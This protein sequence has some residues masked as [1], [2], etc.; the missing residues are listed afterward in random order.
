M[1]T[2]PR[3]RSAMEP[4]IALNEGPSKW[5]LTC[6]N[7]KCNTYYNT[8]APQPHQE[9]FHRDPHRFTGNF[10]GYGLTL[11]SYK[12]PLIAGNSQRTSEGCSGQSAAKLQ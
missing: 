4:A 9:E 6:T 3:C 7:N 5:W 1:I 12:T 11:G 8:Y 10:G 2:C